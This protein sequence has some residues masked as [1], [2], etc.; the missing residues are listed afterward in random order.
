MVRV[1]YTLA[2]VVIVLVLLQTTLR[3]TSTPLG[4]DRED[5]LEAT[6][7]CQRAIRK[8]V[9]DARFPFQPTIGDGEGNGVRLSGSMD[10]GSGPDIERR[11]YVC[12][13]SANAEPGAY[14]TDSVDIWKSH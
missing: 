7:Q 3:T 10:S 5:W 4:E 14:V 2:G 13:L 9:A 11:N 12:Y 8:S 6:R 1:Y